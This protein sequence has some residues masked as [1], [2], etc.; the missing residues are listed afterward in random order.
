MDTQES[1][2]EQYVQWS[3][4]YFAKALSDFVKCRGVL[5]AGGFVVVLAV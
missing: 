4:N 3:D 1:D 2:P 5:A